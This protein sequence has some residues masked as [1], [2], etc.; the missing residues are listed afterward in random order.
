MKT[1]PLLPEETLHRV[2][3]MAN[4]NGLSVLAVSGLL[5]LAVAST[6]DY[7]GAVI[8][9]LVA[10]SG[11]IELHGAG[12]LRAGESR[13]MRWLIASQPYLAVIVLAYCGLRLMD[14][15]PTAIR[16]VMNEERRAQIA[17][18]GYDE[19]SFERVYY[20]S[21][22]AILGVSTLIYQGAM[23]VY[24]GRRRRAVAAALGEEE[25]PPRFN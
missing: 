8:G 17:A 5:T 4:F 3:R 21:M 11:A 10:A 16:Q 24:Y 19:A 2:L 22:Y 1:P 18:L 23:T 13:G 20:V 7:V 12:L 9:L 14:Y 25:E 15:D 6:G